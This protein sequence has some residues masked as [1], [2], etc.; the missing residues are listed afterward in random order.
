[1]SRN[2]ENSIAELKELAKTHRRV[3]VGFSGGKDSL[4]VLD[5]AARFFNE[6]V[7]FCMH[8]V[9]GLQYDADRLRIAEE[10]YGLKVLTFPH[11]IFW[12]YLREEQYVDPIPGFEHLEEIRPWPY[13]RWV[14]HET[15]CTLMLDGMKKSD[16]TFRRRKFASEGEEERRMRHRPLKNWL[17]WEVLNYC[18]AQDLPI[19][20]QD[21]ST[22][23]G[24]SGVSLQ[25]QE[26]LWMHDNAPMDYERIRRAFPFIEAI[27]ARR[28]FFGL[29]DG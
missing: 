23:A 13:Y 25:V 21:N 15:K 26:V 19:P 8:L 6:V 27:V 22:A 17:K 5:L 16:G 4:C 2:V 1:M 10:R 12:N 29:S 3:L 11:F 18:K 7:P 28:E 9:P 14:M 24:N 20:K